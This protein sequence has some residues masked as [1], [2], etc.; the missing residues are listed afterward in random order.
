MPAGKL[1]S[2]E[3][4]LDCAKRELEEETGYT[5]RNIKY[6]ITI[7]TTPGF[8]DEKIHI[9]VATGLKAGQRK[10]DVDEFLDIVEMKI[11]ELI[12]M[13][14]QGSIND[15]KTII[16]AFIAEKYLKNCW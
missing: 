4:P 5:T 14:Y 6:I 11:D 13:I 2:D 12:K 8:S 16:G 10:P 1:D 3:E 7:D 9:F 15:A